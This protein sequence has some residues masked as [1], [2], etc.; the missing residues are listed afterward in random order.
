MLRLSLVLPADRATEAIGVLRAHEG[1]ATVV[2]LPAAAVEPA[3]DL[4]EADVARESADELIDRLRALSTGAGGTLTV[5]ETSA[6]IG[7]RVERAQRAAPGEGVDAV[8]WDQLAERADEDARLSG[9]FL[10]FLVAAT[11]ISVVGILTDSDVLVVGGMVLGPEF[12]PLSSVAL[13]LVRRDPGRALRSAR[14]LVVG[15]PIAIAVTACGVALLGAT[16]GVPP[17][18]LHGHRPLTSF[19][20]QP[21]QFS[22]VVA[23]IAGVAGVVSLTSAKSGALVGVFISVTTIPAAA[24]IGTALVAGRTSDALGAAVQL[25]VNLTCILVAAVLTLLVQRWAWRT[26]RLRPPVRGTAR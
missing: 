21:D 14:T 6:A 3:G 17:G 2:H 23:L 1:V 12:G 24:N 16:I 25:I 19:I 26:K 10:V 22:V 5:T 20:S 7:D 9:A 8:L 11:L 18:Y 15:F 13:A 4:V